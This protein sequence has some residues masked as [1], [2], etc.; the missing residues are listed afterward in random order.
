M[1][2][3]VLAH[4]WYA[5]ARSLPDFAGSGH[6]LLSVDILSETDKC[7]VVID[8]TTTMSSPLEEERAELGYELVEVREGRQLRVVH[9]RCDSSD[10]CFFFVH[11]GGGRAGQFKHLI[12]AFQSR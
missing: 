2:V 1:T 7:T 5:Q 3:V 11:G 6:I 9:R 12:K 8:T 4:A 10:V